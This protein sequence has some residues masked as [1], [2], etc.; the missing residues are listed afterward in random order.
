[1]RLVPVPKTA[2]TGADTVAAEA[3]SVETGGGIMAAEVDLA[4]V[5]ADRVVVAEAGK[6]VAEADRDVAGNKKGSTIT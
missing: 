6:V 3:D 1:M 5:A 4:P 2:I